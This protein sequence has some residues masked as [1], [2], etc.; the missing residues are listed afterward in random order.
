MKKPLNSIYKEHADS[1][2]LN[3]DQLQALQQ[4]QKAHTQSIPEKPK[5]LPKLFTIAASVLIIVTG[6]LLGTLTTLKHSPSVLQS[7]ADEVVYNHLKQ[8]PLEVSGTTV[9]S[10]RD[11]FTKLNFVPAESRYLAQLGLNLEGGRYCSIQ[12]VTAAQLRL[13]APAQIET[14]RTLYQAADRP[15]LYAH[16]PNYEVGEKPTI[17]WS[18]GVK[19]SVWREKGVLFALAEEPKPSQ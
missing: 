6:V 16:L 2:S 3:A 18:K 13:Q 12:G 1:K 14:K 17:A 15:E 11:Y 9:A 7:I 8:M 5:R 19:V 4:L 10:V